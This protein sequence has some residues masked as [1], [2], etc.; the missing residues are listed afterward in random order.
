MEIK[1]SFARIGIVV[2]LL[3]TA[4][5]SQKELTVEEWKQQLVFVTPPLGQDPTSMIAGISNV[6]IL[7][8]GAHFE[9]E[10]EYSGAVQGVSV[11]AHVAIGI[12]VLERQVSRSEL[13]TVLGVTIDSHYE[14]QN[15]AVDVTVEG[16]EWLDGEGVPVRIEEEVTINVGGFDVPMGFMLNRTGENMCGDRECWVFMGTQTINLSG[17][18]ESRILGYLDKESGIVVR[19]MTSI[20]GE[21]VDTGFMEPPVTVDTFTWELGSQESV[22]T[23]RGRIKCQVIH[24]MDNSQKV[25][26]LW[27]NKDIPIPVQIVRSYMS[28]YMDLNVTVTLVSYQ[29]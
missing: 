22:S 19:A 28:S 20:G 16:T 29:V 3:S 17:L 11:D 7:P 24:L 25:G 23:D 27:V 18:G 14:S 13:L 15:E 26:T 12:T 10:A 8:V 9:V 6:G 4:C 21:E 2:L 5:I 1:S